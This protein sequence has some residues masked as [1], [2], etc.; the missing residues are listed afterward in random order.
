MGWDGEGSPFPLDDDSVTHHVVDRPMTSGFDTTRDYVQPQWVFDSIN[1]RM[2][3]PVYK[4]KPGVSL[5]PHLSPFVDDDIEG[6]LPKYRE[7]IFKLQS[8][9]GVLSDAD[10]KKQLEKLEE[11]EE[12]EKEQEEEEESDAGDDE[13]MDDATPLSSSSAPTKKSKKKDNKQKFEEILAVAD[14]DKESAKKKGT[15]GVVFEP[16]QG[17]ISEV[18]VYTASLLF[19][20]YV[21]ACMYVC[22]YGHMSFIDFANENTSTQIA[23]KGIVV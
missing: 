14:E 10:K 15:K 20:A 17:K 8:A 4:Y 5:P 18:S 9:A 22:M 6:Y 23:L 2:R 3:L 21:Y 1:A 7:E 13:E 12:D 19:V 11:D 16:K